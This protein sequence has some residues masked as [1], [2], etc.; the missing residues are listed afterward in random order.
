MF[1]HNSCH[2]RHVRVWWKHG[3][4]NSRFVQKR[5]EREE[6]NG[7]K[8]VFVKVSKMD[9]IF[10]LFSSFNSEF[11]ICIKRNIKKCSMYRDWHDLCWCDD[12]TVKSFASHP[13]KWSNN[14][15]WIDRFKKYKIGKKPHSLIL[16]WFIF[17]YT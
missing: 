7:I 14:T 5:V 8:Y 16:V 10:V 1:S 17:L 11:K 4:D 2:G 13:I 6:K 15:Y 12:K 3:F 9:F